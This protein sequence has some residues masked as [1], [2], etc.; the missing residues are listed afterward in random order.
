LGLAATVHIRNM[1]TVV[2]MKKSVFSAVHPA[3]AL[4]ARARL[5]S[6]NMAV[7]TINAFIVVQPALAH[8]AIALMESM[9]SNRA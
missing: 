8:V 7:E 4:V 9:K 1:S 3:T 6:T 2:W 5:I